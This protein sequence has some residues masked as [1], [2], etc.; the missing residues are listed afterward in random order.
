MTSVALPLLHAL[1]AARLPAASLLLPLPV[2]VTAAAA[3]TA[4]AGV[5]ASELRG[6]ALGDRDD[7][8]LKLNAS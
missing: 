4:C 3:E 8:V 5:R 2:A 6:C 1:P 7:V